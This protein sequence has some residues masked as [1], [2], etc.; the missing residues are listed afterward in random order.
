MNPWRTTRRSESHDLSGSCPRTSRR[1]RAA[2][3]PRRRLDPS[4]ERSRRARRCRRAGVQG[5]D[6]TMD[7]RGDAST[8]T[9]RSFARWIQRRR[10]RRARSRREVRGH[11]PEDRAIRIDALSPRIHFRRPPRS[12][13]ITMERNGVLPAELALWRRAAIVVAAMPGDFKLTTAFEPQADQP[14][15]IEQL[16]KGVFGD[17]KHQVLS[18]SPDR[19]DVHDRERHR[20]AMASRRSSSRR[21]KTLA[22]QLYGEMK[23]LLPPKRRRVLRPLLRLHQPEAYVPASDPY[24]DKDRDHQRPD[25]SHASRGRRARCSR[26]KDASSSPP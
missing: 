16:V 23:E 5:R 18:A 12:S 3:A 8:S 1:L 26:G 10:G 11:E 13:K 4:R 17:E 9:S 6:L 7:L 15:A 2:P 14:Q 24:I 22:A 21:T 25:R 19:Q 20:A